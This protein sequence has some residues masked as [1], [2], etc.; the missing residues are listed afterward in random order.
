MIHFMTNADENVDMDEESKS[1]EI[2][3]DTEIDEVE[4]EDADD[5]DDLEEVD[6]EEIEEIP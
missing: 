5:D 4:D 3:D 1:M 6:E 2:L